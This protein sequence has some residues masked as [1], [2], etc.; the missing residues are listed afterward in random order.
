LWKLNWFLRD[1]GYDHDLFL[2]DEIDEKALLDL[3]GVIKTSRTTLNGR[4]FLNL[5][6]FAPAGNW[7]EL[8]AAAI[9]S[10]DGQENSND[11]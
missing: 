11:L 4:S 1:F 6:A 9:V 5:E 8:A 7:E 10:R 3:T 2:R